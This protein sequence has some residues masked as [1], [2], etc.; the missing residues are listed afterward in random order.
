MHHR[1]HGANPHCNHLNPEANVMREAI[2]SQFDRLAVG[3]IAKCDCHAADAAVARAVDAFHVYSDTP[4][5][6]RAD[7]LDKTAAII[8]QRIEEF[9][10]PS[11]KEAGNPLY[12]AR[13]EVSRATSN[14]RNAA[15]E[16]RR[17]AGE[18]TPIIVDDALF[19]GQYCI[20]VQQILV[21]EN[22]YDEFSV[23]LRTAIPAVLTGNLLDDGADRGPVTDKRSADR[24]QEW[25]AEKE[26]IFGPVVIVRAFCDVDSAIEKVNAS[27][28][29][30]QAS[31]FANNLRTA[32]R[33]GDRV[34]AGAVLVNDTPTFRV[35]NM[36][37]GGR[38]QSG[39]GREGTR[40]STEAFTDPRRLVPDYS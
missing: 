30:L 20:G 23:K 6:E 16:T 33:A 19:A 2:R 5:F 12:D 18:E 31:I 36:P 10:R 9:A 4:L 3:T 13:G 25:M 26:T 1:D 37:F 8:S 15:A 39:L 28:Y 11:A 21:H 24:I 27:K 29:S 35:D 40:W 38:K 22:R 17:F 32:M 7:I 34:D 14:V